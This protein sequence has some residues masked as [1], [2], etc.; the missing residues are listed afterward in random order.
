MHPYNEVFAQLKTCDSVDYNHWN[1]CYNCAFPLSMLTSVCIRK[2]VSM[3]EILHALT[4]QLA[5]HG[6]A[7]KCAH[8]AGF[9][10]NATCG[11]RREFWARFR[12][13]NA[14]HVSLTR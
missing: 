2:G 6:V 4:T 13:K 8:E 1:M 9:C 5:A 10:S 3:R 11:E 14:D 12:W 7:M